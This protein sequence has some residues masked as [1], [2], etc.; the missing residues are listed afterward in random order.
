M[1]AA[2]SYPLFIFIIYSE[3]KIPNL[4]SG[5]AGEI[6]EVEPV[7]TGSQWKSLRA[8]RGTGKKIII[9]LTAGECKRAWQ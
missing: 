4:I 7:I 1:F 3:A 9:G 6:A 5:Y 2:F 8:H